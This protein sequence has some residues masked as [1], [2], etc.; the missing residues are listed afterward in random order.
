MFGFIRYVIKGLLPKKPLFVA[1]DSGGRRKPTIVLLHGIAATSK[2]WQPLIKQLDTNT[3]R[4][5]AL[6]LLGFGGSQKPFTNQYTVDDHVQY[7]RKTLKKLRVKKPYKI[8]GHSM[9]AIIS[10][11]IGYMFPMDV[12]EIVLLS[13]PIYIDDPGLNIIAKKRTDFYKK[14]YDFLMQNKDFTIKNS[15]I[16]RDILRIEDGIDVNQDNWFS[17]K[18]SLKNTIINQDV[19]GDIK[20][21]Y[22]PTHIVFGSLDEFLVP[23]CIQKLE[24]FEH[25]KITKLTGVNHLLGNRFSKVVAGLLSDN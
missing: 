2:T 13:V 20:K 24:K 12:S 5:I 21:S 4:V 10:A 22:K 8:V 3:Y 23:D 25:V 6:D 17:F 11:R 19:Y 9:G 16:L 1:Y 14:A 15:K 18:Q 7:V